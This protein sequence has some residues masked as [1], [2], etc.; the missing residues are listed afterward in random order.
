MTEFHMFRV[1]QFDDN[2]RGQEAVIKA[3]NIDDAVDYVKKTYLTDEEQ[4]EVNEDGDEG[5]CYLTLLQA[6]AANADDFDECYSYGFEIFQDDDTE[7]EFHTIYGGNDFVD[8][9]NPENSGKPTAKVI[10]EH[11]GQMKAFYKHSGSGFEQG[12]PDNDYNLNTSNLK[13]YNP[14]GETK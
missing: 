1:Y 9:I 13:L 3:K 8:L 6:G 7:P 12:N 10:K 5:Q 11:G 4:R 2:D 14:K